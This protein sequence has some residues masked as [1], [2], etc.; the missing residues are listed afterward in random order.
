VG[1]RVWFKLERLL[2]VAYFGALFL[3]LQRFVVISVVLVAVVVVIVIVQC[4]G[5]LLCF[6]NMR[7]K[8]AHIKKCSLWS[9]LE[10]CSTMFLR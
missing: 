2:F 10:K 7:Y 3:S 9:Y 1:T 4:S 5:T 8:Q 6:S